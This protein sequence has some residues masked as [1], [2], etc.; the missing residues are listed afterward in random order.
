MDTYRSPIL[1][2]RRCQVSRQRRSFTREFKLEAVRLANEGGR[3]LSQVARE[4]DLRPDLLRTWRRK[5][6][7]EGSVV[8]D[9]S[10]ESAEAEL[11]RVRRELDVV[12][13]E[14]DFLKKAAA[15]FAKGSRG[16]TP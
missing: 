5:F 3:P 4:L 8:V 14:R 1:R 7:D 15:Y 10:T 12:R 6:E 9:R 2:A 11:R 16:G 13:M